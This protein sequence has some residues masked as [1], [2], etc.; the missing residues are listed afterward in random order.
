MPANRIIPQP[1]IGLAVQETGMTQATGQSKAVEFQAQR[2]PSPAMMF[3]LTAN[4][5]P[6]RV[7]PFGLMERFNAGV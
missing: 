7:K 4:L 3:I 2:F 6:R 5:F 1:V